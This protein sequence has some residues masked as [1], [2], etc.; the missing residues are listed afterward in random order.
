MI[1]G[2]DAISQEEQ[3]QISMRSPFDHLY[4]RGVCDHPNVASVYRFLASH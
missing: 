1:T 3:Q 2:I 4:S